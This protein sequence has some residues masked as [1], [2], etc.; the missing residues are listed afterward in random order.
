MSIIS[1]YGLD[2]ASRAYLILALS[3]D[4]QKRRKASDILHLQKIVRY[5]EFLRQKH[6]IDFS[7]YKL[8]QVSYELEENIQT[9]LEIGLIEKK[10][11]L[12]QLTDEGMKAASELRK[13]FDPEDLRKVAFSKLQLNDLTSDE[14]MFFMYELIPESQANSTEANRLLKRRKELTESLFKKGRISAAMAAKWLE[15]DEQTFLSSINK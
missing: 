14:L 3:E 10:G 4:D 6:E 12:Y 13:R 15:I 5:F 1:D 7:N 8:G 2:L 11:N 9:L